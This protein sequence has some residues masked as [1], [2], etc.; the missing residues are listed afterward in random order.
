M[1]LGFRC[2][3]NVIKVLGIDIHHGWATFFFKIVYFV[4]ELVSIAIVSYSLYS[5]AAQQLNVVNVVTI[6]LCVITRQ[7]VSKNMEKLINLLENLNT[8]LDIDKEDEV[9]RADKVLAISI[10]LCYSFALIAAS[11]DTFGY[12]SIHAIDIGFNIR[13]DNYAALFEM[14]V[15]FG[16]LYHFYMVAIFVCLYCMVQYVFVKH[17]QACRSLFK[18]HLKSSLNDQEL[19]NYLISCKNSYNRHLVGNR[20]VNQLIGFIPFAFF[21]MF[22]VFIIITIS[23]LIVNE[24]SIAKSFLVLSVLPTVVTCI[25]ITTLLVIMACIA[26]DEFEHARLEA[27]YLAINFVTCN[28]QLES[29]RQTSKSLHM[30]ISM[31]KPAYASAWGCF[32]ID[33]QLLLRFSNAVIPVAVMIITSSLNKSSS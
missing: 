6:V 10:G 29:I 15:L 1:K 27:G 19:L 12:N 8:S 9:K 23:H 26:T 33:R 30:L 18:K 14:I 13:P 5:K 7:V 21:S 2:M 32:D 31:E 3:L 25:A 28:T 20:Q 17:A 24:E 16:Y 11:F 22:F 4:M